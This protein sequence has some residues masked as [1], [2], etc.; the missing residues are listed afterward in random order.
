MTIF[1]LISCVELCKIDD[2]LLE[3]SSIHVAGKRESN[4]FS[5]HEGREKSKI[6]LGAVLNN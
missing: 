4:D 2:I 3:F 5:K 6:L 1:L